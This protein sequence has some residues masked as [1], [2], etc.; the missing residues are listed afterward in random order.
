M[1][2]LV[3]PGGFE[4]PAKN[5]E[6]SCSIQLSYGD[7]HVA[8]TEF[9]YRSPQRRS[10][11]SRFHLRPL[12]RRRPQAL[13]HPGFPYSD[14]VA[15]SRHILDISAEAG[16][17]ETYPKYHAN[18]DLHGY[19]AYL[20]R[21]PEGTECTSRRG[22]GCTDRRRFLFCI[23]SLTVLFLRT[24]VHSCPVAW[25]GPRRHTAMWSFFHNS[26]HSYRSCT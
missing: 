12:P 13:F 15:L 25:S 5:L 21:P 19:P 17:V 23:L 3:P 10:R 26:Q 24:C 14:R 11:E 18:E 1:K 16:Y 8:D 6:G 7:R 2:I 9:L 4:P 20:I 22:I